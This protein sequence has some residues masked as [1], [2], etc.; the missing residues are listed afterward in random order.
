[1]IKIGTVGHAVQDDVHAALRVWSEKNFTK[2][3][4]YIHKVNLL[5]PY[6]DTYMHAYIHHTYIHTYIIIAV[7]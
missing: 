7:Y 1:M 6:I 4:K 2:T 5:K 3:V